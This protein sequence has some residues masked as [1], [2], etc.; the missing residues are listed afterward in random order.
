MR[1]RS[2]SPESCFMK[3]NLPLVPRSIVPVAYWAQLS[4]QPPK[5]SVQACGAPGAGADGDDQDGGL[6]ESA[7]WPLNSGMRRLPGNEEDMAGCG[8]PI[9]LELHVRSHQAQVLRAPRSQLVGDPSSGRSPR[10]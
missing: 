9:C 3:P 4:P 2:S 8:Q 7:A 5:V 6:G 10:R 1:K